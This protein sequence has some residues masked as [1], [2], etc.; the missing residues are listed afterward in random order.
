MLCS[1][2]SKVSD[3]CRVEM[4]QRTQRRL[5]MPHLEAVPDG[6]MAPPWSWSEFSVCLF[7]LWPQRNRMLLFWKGQK[8]PLPGKG[9]AKHQRP[10]TGH[11]LPGRTWSPDRQ[12]PGAGT[13][14]TAVCAGTQFHLQKLRYKLVLRYLSATI[15]AGSLSAGARTC[16]S[17]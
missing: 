9:A 6:V 11:Q 13:G 7:L 17:A 8:H 15:A 12:G 16:V 14:S 2:T 5:E 4:G 1:E 10:G 3:L